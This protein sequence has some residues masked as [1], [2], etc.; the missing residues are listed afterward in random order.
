MDIQP[1]NILK[2]TTV[3]KI[4]VGA[5]LRAA[6]ERAGLSLTD[7]AGH[8]KFAPRQIEALE[9][10]DFIHLPEMPFVRGFVR[11][12]AKLLQIDAAPLLVALPDSPTKTVDAL[13]VMKSKNVPFLGVYA[14]R[15]YNIV[16][17]A[18][19]L[20]V[21][22]VLAIFVWLS[23]GTNAVFKTKV[24]EVSLPASAI[25]VTQATTVVPQGDNVDS[26]AAQ[27][28]PVVADAEPARLVTLVRMVF[29]E[30]AWVEVMDKDGAVLMAQLN[31]AGSERNVRGINS[32]FTVKIGNASKVQLFY[33]GQQVDLTP[34]SRAGVARLTL[35]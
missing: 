18:G 27:A 8:L 34:H 23:N 10:D 33:K 12:Y 32:P 17:L 31:L 16:W 35:E 1:D 14:A 26:S 5:T 24:V 28:T 25:S 3:Q 4:S 22:L 29:E 21:A 13:L 2:N 9:A 30:D 15:K 7:V 6:R 11:N 20:V 19:G